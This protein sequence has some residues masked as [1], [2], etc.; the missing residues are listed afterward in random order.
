MNP[1]IAQA[2]EAWKHGA[3]M[4]GNEDIEVEYRTKVSKSHFDKVSERLTATLGDPTIRVTKEDIVGPDC[5]RV[6]VEDAQG[7]TY[8]YKK[9]LFVGDIE[10][11][12]LSVC[13]ERRG[14]PPQQQQQGIWR[15]KTRQSWLQGPWRWD[16]TVVKTNDPRY[17]DEDEDL[18]EIELE[19]DMTR[20]E[21]L[22]YTMDRLLEDGLEVFTQHLKM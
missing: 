16:M 15:H 7:P 10:R 12:R 11:T 20:D 18:Y 3:I 8:V 4:F 21:L 5:R 6:V 13:L 14:D 1:T 17:K 9:R 2:L 22:Y 19:L